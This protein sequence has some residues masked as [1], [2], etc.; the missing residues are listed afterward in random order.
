M[1][2]Y[3]KSVR[4]SSKT[5]YAELVRS[6]SKSVDPKGVF[7]IEDHSLLAGV[8]FGFGTSKLVAFFFISESWALE[9]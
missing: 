3:T 6:G 7:I 5:K 9:L 2:N 4:C 8:L 1:L